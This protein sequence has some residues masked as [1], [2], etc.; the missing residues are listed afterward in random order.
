MFVY[1]LRCILNKWGVKV[2][3]ISFGV[4]AFQANPK[5]LTL[6]LTLTP[7]SGGGQWLTINEVGTSGRSQWENYPTT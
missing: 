2:M 6:S 7:T 1:Q 4:N 5:I 3:Y